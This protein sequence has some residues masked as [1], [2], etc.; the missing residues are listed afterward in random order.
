MFKHILVAT[1]A[2]E[3]SQQTAQRGLELAKQLGA[4]VTALYVVPIRPS[5]LESFFTPAALD[6]R[7]TAQI[8]AA[9]KSRG[10]RAL[11]EIEQS[12]KKMGVAFERVIQRHADVWKAI[13]RMADS[14]ECDLIVMAA[15]G[16]RGL[17]ALLIGSETQ[18]VLTH[19]KIPVLVY[20]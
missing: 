7:V 6:E 1:D 5:L 15:H 2:S 17:E 11:D 19:S 18:K 20:R 10:E 16:R 3:H 14:D 4:S 12:A 9:F 8:E 13:L